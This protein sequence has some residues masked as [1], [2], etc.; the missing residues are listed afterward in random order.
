MTLGEILLVVWGLL[1]TGGPLLK[2]ASGHISSALDEDS[3]TTPVEDVHQLYLAGEIDESEMERRLE[4]LVDDRARVIRDL[5]DDQDGIGRELSRRVA[6][7]YDTVAAFAAADAEELQQIDDIGE[8]R[9]EKLAQAEPTSSRRESL[10]NHC[11]Q[12]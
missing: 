11:N 6:R 7:E 5:A 4:V 3:G 9:A 2:R 8:A 12:K 1:L 10:Q